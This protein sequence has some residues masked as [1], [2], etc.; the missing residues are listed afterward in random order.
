M[1]DASY[2]AVIIGAGHN[3]LSLATY[4]A[5]CGWSTAVFE[6][7]GEE[8]GGL[9][10]EELTR[11]GFLHNVHCNYHTLVGVC[12][13]YDDL[14]LTRHGLR[15]VQPPVQMA[16]VFADGSALTVHTDLDKTCASIVR[17]S[18]KDA[19]TFRRLYEETQGYRDLIL[20]TLM[21]S[22]PISIRD[23]TKALVTWGVEGKSEFLSVRL[24]NM[25]INEFLDR[26]FENERVKAHLAFHAAL[27]GY[28]SD[29]R[30]L[31]VSFP[32]LLGKID[33]WHVCVGGSHA[34]AHSLWEA[35]SHAGGVVFLK[36][37]VAKI[38]VEGGKATGVELEDGSVIKARHLVASSI[39]L[40]QT[41][42]DMLR[43]D[44]VPSTLVSEV[45]RYPHMDWSFFSVH[46]AM[47]EA[48]RYRAADFDP[49]VQSGLGHQP[50]LR[51]P[52]ANRP[53]LAGRARRR[54][55]RSEAQLRRQ[56][57]VRSLR[58]SR[59]LLHRL[60]APGC[61]LQPRRRRRQ[62]VGRRGEELWPALHRSLDGGGAQHDR[63]RLPG[64]DHLHA[65]G[66]FAADA[67]HGSRRLDGW[68][69]RSR[70]PARSPPERPTLAVSDADRESVYVRRD[71]ASARLRNL[72]AGVQ[73][74][75]DHRR[76]LSARALVAMSTRAQ[77][78]AIE[79][80]LAGGASSGLA[81]IVEQYLS[82]QLSESEARRR[83]A[84]R[85]R[86]RLSLTA[87]D[88]DTSVTVEFGG[89][90][91]AIWDGVQAPLD[92][93][94]AGSYRTLTRLLQG[95]A[96]PL[97]EH[98]RGRLKVT[99]RLRKILLPIRVHQLMKLSPKQ[100]PPARL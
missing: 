58:R 34:L 51:Q 41:F 48:P 35:L 30:G 20:R 74:A 73:R 97:I 68:F 59:R 23:I 83:R 84:A 79:V 82:Q 50:R 89:N 62:S 47:T 44:Q 92:T 6:K 52:G 75:P 39:S 43:R 61:S 26:H 21:Y 36:H 4:L 15:Y 78:S 11:P 55:A 10:T 5:R 18:R 32:L 25:T 27:A 9:C 67:E 7:R 93:K 72:R 96:N 45:E 77:R 33:N 40:E 14:E 37:G 31:A 91:I 85:I 42:L 64:M 69:D 71:P 60:A 2:D 49:D 70:Q 86:G 63:A 87:T 90:G 95:R 24:R 13:V 1:P 8:G 66:Y 100:E 56:L 38:L 12:P 16:S 80:R 46:L 76:R 99:S 17:F 65:A 88:Y 19:D 28:A 57:A 94:I 29:R 81:S 98:F 3:G 54:S 22:P 53:R